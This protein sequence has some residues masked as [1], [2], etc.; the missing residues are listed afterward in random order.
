MI[1]VSIIIPFYN[2]KKEYLE[3]AVQSVLNQTLNDIEV[4]CIDDGSDSKECYNY[5]KTLQGSD[6]RIKLYNKEH[7]GSGDSRNLG[8]LYGTGENIMFLD[9]DDYYPKN[10]I[11]E[12][13]YNLKLENNVQIAGGKHLIL[14]NNNL[15]EP[16]FNYG[17]INQF[18]CNKRIKYS[19]Y[20]FPWWYWCF[21]FDSNL[22]KENNLKFP[23]YLRYQDPPFF[24]RLMDKA[25]YFYAADFVSYIHRNSGK[26]F[27]LNK[28]TA[29]H[30][31]EG[32]SDLLSYAKENN[33]GKLRTLLYN[34]F[35]SF[36]IKILKNINDLPDNEL[37]EMKQKIDKAFNLP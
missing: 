30:H 34:T 27:E 20:Q 1:K 25:K 33:L 18:F 12:K 3:Q 32:I 9:S 10:D 23:P 17:D 16:Y 4:L 36:D 37:N 19:D 11:L 29:K 35:Y 31:V 26:L 28:I 15:E 7:S 6:N 8:L 2:Q 5:L 22:I 13:L 24:V 14:N 21:M